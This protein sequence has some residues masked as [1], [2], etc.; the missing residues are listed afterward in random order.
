MEI[1]V[2]KGIRLR[3]ALTAE[4]KSSLFKPKVAL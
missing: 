2:Q 1:P 3:E 4:E